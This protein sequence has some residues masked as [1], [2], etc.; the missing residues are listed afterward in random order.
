MTDAWALLLGAEGDIAALTGARAVSALLP[1]AEGWAV[2][3]ADKQGAV[4]STVRGSIAAAPGVVGQ[5]VYL[6]DGSSGVRFESD[7]ELSVWSVSLHFQL[8]A[9]PSSEMGSTPYI[10]CF[11]TGSWEYGVYVI[12][13]FDYDKFFVDVFSDDWNDYAYFESADPDWVGKWHHVALV[14]DGVETRVYVDGVRL[15]HVVEWGPADF[16]P[17]LPIYGVAGVGQMSLDGPDANLLIDDLAVYSG[18]LTEQ[19]IQELVSGIAAP[20]ITDAPSLAA[21]F[22]FDEVATISA[23][24]E[25]TRPFRNTTTTASLSSSLD[26]RYAQHP[27]SIASSLTDLTYQFTISTTSRGAASSQLRTEWVR[28]LE[29]LVSGVASD[30]L[31]GDYIASLLD[32][33]NF[34]TSVSLVEAVPVLD[35][36]L[37]SS[38]LETHVQFV[39]QLISSLR[40]VSLISDAD[41]AL[42]QSV[43]SLAA[44]LEDRLL[45]FAE[46]MD[47]HDIVVSVEARRRLTLVLTDTQGTA[48]DLSLQAYFKQNLHDAVV[49]HFLVRLGE[50]DYV[51]WV[52]NTEGRMPLS[53]YRNFDFNSL[54]RVGDKYYAAADEGLFV[55]GGDTDD[56]E[57]IEA[58]LATMMLDF[59]SPVQKRVHAAYLGYTSTGRLVLK[60]RSVDSGEVVEDWYEAKDIDALVPSAQMVRLGRGLRS[61]YWQFEL[62]NVA[63]SDFELDSL[64]VH[65]VYLNRRV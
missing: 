1:G 37:A 56:G 22:P 64:E 6:P 9:I 38:A 31:R 63:G 29:M 24:G 16:T 28:V 50:E 11:T 21:Y 42:V 18:V 40:G 62:M 32:V 34:D 33:M 3:V 54:A 55:L 5:A 15:A 10:M 57:E 51:G 7:I 17:N 2:S 30:R 52:M 23:L 44:T 19:Q 49:A 47:A 59:G 14:G 20:D 41:A 60:V 43:G 65:P 4:S 12:P 13:D 45:R 46:V 8:T 27:Q 35:R 26:G 25:Y 39:Q 61:R 58:S 48:T 36:L 53:E